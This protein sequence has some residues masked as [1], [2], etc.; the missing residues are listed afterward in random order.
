MEEVKPEVL[1]LMRS[2]EFW[3]AVFDRADKDTSCNLA[4]KI[5]TVLEGHRRLDCLSALYVV[6]AFIISEGM[7]GIR[8]GGDEKGGNKGST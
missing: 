2:P 5:Y 6:Q 3:K 4:H 1:E 8:G 7:Y